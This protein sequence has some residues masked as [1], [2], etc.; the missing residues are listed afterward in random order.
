MTVA[1]LVKVHD[2]LV[3]AA[4]S[5]TTLRLDDNSAQVYNNADKIIQLHRNLPLAMMTWGLGQIGDASVSTAGKD[6]R[7]RLMGK[8]KKYDDWKLKKH[9]YTVE[10]VVDRLV[11]M[12]HE[13][14]GKMDLPADDPNSVLGV[15]VCGYSAGCDH[16]EAYQV[17]LGPG[18]P[19]I[20]KVAATGDFG[21]IAFAQAVATN[22]LFYGID[23]ILMARIEKLV[24]EDRHEELAE[25]LKEQFRQ[26]VF[27]AMPFPDAIALAK[28]LVE[29]TAGYSHFLLGP[30]TVGGPIDVA[31]VNRH[32]GFKWINRKHYYSSELNPGGSR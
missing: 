2:G 23:P 30:D 28:F 4:D 1:V 12:F 17:M 16:A 15:L 8:T 14:I 26:P 24:P 6:L 32:E 7:R 21:W 11:D 31:S 20:E 29:V 10:Q 25:A 22:R 18:E 9:K 27:R 5:A 13:R 19:S 3:L